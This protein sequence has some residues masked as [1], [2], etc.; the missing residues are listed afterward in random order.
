ML[1]LERGEKPPWPGRLSSHA[2][3]GALA[4]LFAGCT[5]ATI[6][7]MASGAPAMGMPIAGGSAVAFLAMWAVM[8]VAMML[9]S[10]APRLWGYRE[11]MAGIGETRPGWLAALLGLGYFTVWTVAG[12]VAFPLSMTLAVTAMGPPAPASAVPFAVSGVVLIAGCFQLTRFKSRH[13]AHCRD[14]YGPRAV[15][16]ASAGVAWNQGVCLGLHCIRCCIGPMAVLLALGLTHLWAMAVV[17]AAIAAERLAPA[18]EYV[19]RATGLAAIVVGLF[20]LARAAGL[21]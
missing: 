21:G 18:G 14:M 5:A 11:A 16:V 7:W 13:L 9:P 1:Q 12:L 19:A 6:G 4:L 20:L 15:P 10:V 3:V 17:A 2:F 8:T